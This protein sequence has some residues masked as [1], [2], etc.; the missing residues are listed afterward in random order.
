MPDGTWGAFEIKIG[1][2]Q[3]DVAAEKLLHIKSHI[4]KDPKG[5][6]PRILGVICGLSNAV[7]LRPDGVYVIPI[8][9]LKP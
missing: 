5:K 3:L 9:A 4:E 6:L 1:A 2:H 8:T 7:Y